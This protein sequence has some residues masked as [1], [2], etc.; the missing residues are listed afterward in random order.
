MTVLTEPDGGSPEFWARHRPGTIAI[1]DGERTLT[2]AEWNELSDR[3]ADA[4][5]ARGLQPG[6]RLGMRFRIRAEWFVVQRALQKL[7]VVQVAVNWKLTPAEAMYIITDSEAVGLACDDADASGWAGLDIG[8]LITVGQGSGSPGVRYEDLIAEGAPVPRFGPLRP[9]M[10]LYTSGTTGLPKGVPPL[11]PATVDLERLARYSASCAAVPPHPAEVCVL[12]ALPVHHGAGP[13]AAMA[14][15]ARGGTAVLLDPYDPEEALRLIERHR[16]Q[17]WT[18]VPTMLL[19][20]QALPDEVVDRFDL[21]SITALNTGAAPVP[22]SLKEWIIA[23]FGPDVLL[24]GLRRERGRDG[25]VHLARAP[26]REARQ[27]WAA[28]RRRRDRDRRRELEPSA[29]RHNR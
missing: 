6:D 24:G 28:L 16:V 13:A 5:A 22:Q 3:V 8:R 15:C 25:V 7:G 9:N 2:Y 11:D 27:Q 12:M 29:G 1:V 10:V 20:I 26:T 14:A 23:R 19:R 18:S 4:L 17:V 21:S